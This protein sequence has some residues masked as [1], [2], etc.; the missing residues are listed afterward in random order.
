MRMG[1]MAMMISACF[2]VFAKEQPPQGCKI[3]PSS[4]ETVV[5]PKDA[6][7]MVLIQNLSKD[8]LWIT[9]PVS[10]PSASAGWSSRLQGKKWSALVVKAPAFEL[11]CIESRPGHEQQIPCEEAVLV[12]L[13]KPVHI[14]EKMKGTFWAAEDMPLADLI[15]YLGKNGYGLPESSE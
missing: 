9:H 4:G 8:D 11:S 2:A 1:L 14:P 12:C 13:W 7:G 6:P 15:T 3:Y 5:L 10:E